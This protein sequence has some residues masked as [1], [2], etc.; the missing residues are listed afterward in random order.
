LDATTTNALVW[1][2]VVLCLTQSAMF[3]GLNLAFFSLSRF[4]LQIAVDAGDRRAARVLRMR[5]DS[6]FL[7]TTIL[8]GNVGINV[9]LT[10]L[11]GSVLAG[12]FAFVFS[13][14]I[15]TFGGEILPQAYFS[16]HALRTASLLAPVLRVYQFIL[17]PV[18]LPSAR[19]LDAWLGRESITYFRETELRELI[20][21]HM[22]SPAADDVDPV[23]GLGA[24]N[25]LALDDILVADEGEPL[26]EGSIVTLP[27]RD[28]S[29]T[30]ALPDVPGGL[31]DPFVQKVNA[32]GHK[33]VI[34]TDPDN[35]PQ[36][37]LDAD[38]FLR[39]VIT[40]GS[41]AVIAHHC[42]RPIIVLDPSLPLGRIIGRLQAAGH[43]SEDDVID[44]DV[45]L[46]WGEQ[47]RIITGADI[48]GRLLR[49]IS[50]GSGPSDA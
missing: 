7:L 37:A 42:H 47:R 49:G 21:Q 35:E 41:E 3:S 29:N 25:F 31:D 33:W 12:I 43:R 50:S 30:I 8:W 9:L 48:L 18:A 10:L 23:E 11:L 34:L 40:N 36:I 19:M 39:D 4:Q 28:G 16:R 13:T 46:L 5:D 24:M 38:G 44:N 45:V 20:R 2:G 15:I 6:S 26:D 1:L 14:V 32:S 27:F 22:D 17:A